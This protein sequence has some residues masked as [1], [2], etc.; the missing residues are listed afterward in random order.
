MIFTRIHD[1]LSLKDLDRAL[2][3]ARVAVIS[4]YARGNVSFQNG[5]ILDEEG[6][7]KIQHCGDAAVIELERSQQKYVPHGEPRRVRL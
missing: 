7:A 4:R 6:L 5:G 1:W 2:E 3:S